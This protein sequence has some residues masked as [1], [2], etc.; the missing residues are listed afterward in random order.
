MVMK[1]AR[2]SP[3]HR[4]RA[5]PS[6]QQIGIKRIKNKKYIPTVCIY[7]YC[8]YQV[9]VHTVHVVCDKIYKLLVV[10]VRYL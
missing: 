1:N 6:Y 2:T 7:V 10:V 5:H 3:S 4:A 8:M 9:Q